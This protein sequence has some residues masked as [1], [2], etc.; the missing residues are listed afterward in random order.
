MGIFDFLFKKP[1]VIEDDFFGTL[2][3]YEIKKMPENSYFDGKRHFKPIDTTVDLTIDADKTGPT[4][5]QKDFFKKIED[6]FSMIISNITP[7]I[8]DLFQNWKEDFKIQDFNR[9]F[10][11]I[12]LSIPRCETQPNNWE[13]SFAT[14]HDQNHI[15]GITMKDWIPQDIVMDG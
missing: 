9:E 5:T 13:I 10:P 3:Y 2:R 8:E 12:F 15:I 14:I 11:T 6:E 4:Q 7:M 1:Y